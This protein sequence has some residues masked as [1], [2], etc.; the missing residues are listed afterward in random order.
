VK[1]AGKTKM[2][3]PR[4]YT[5]RLTERQLKETLKALR[6]AIMDPEVKS[7]VTQKLGASFVNNGNER[8][9]YEHVL[10][11]WEQRLRRQRWNETA[12]QSEERRERQRLWKAKKVQDKRAKIA[13]LGQRQSQ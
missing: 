7:E 11:P 1:E 6:H 8:L 5:I 13:G 2:P 4:A 9:D 3:S 10:T 12:A